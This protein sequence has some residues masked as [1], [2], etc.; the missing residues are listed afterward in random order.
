MSLSAPWTTHGLVRYVVFFVIQLKTRMVEIAGI[1]AEPDG[2]WMAQL[3]RNLTDP[4]DGFLRSMQYIIL[5][6]DPLYCPYQK[7]RRGP[8]GAFDDLRSRS[9]HMRLETPKAR[10]GIVIDEVCT[11]ARRPRI[12]QWSGSVVDESNGQ[13]ARRS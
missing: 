10:F 12:V 1:T 6:R 4:S 2:A 5:D 3:A 9:A 7:L 11:V 8:C 13:A